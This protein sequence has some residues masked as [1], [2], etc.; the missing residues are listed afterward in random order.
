MRPFR[1]SALPLVLLALFAVV[2]P[3]PPAALAEEASAPAAEAAAPAATFLADYLSEVD[4]VREQIL[5]LAAA[6]P[7]E[8]Y[9]WRPAEGVR[10]VS[11]VYLHIA[12]A[13]YML[14]AV[15]GHAPPADLAD[16]LGVAKIQAWDTSTTDKAAVADKLSRSFDHLRSTVAGLAEADLEAKVDFFGQQ[17]T[18]RQLLLLALGHMHEHLG[19]SIAYAR[20]N[21]VAP[22]W[23]AAQQEALREAQKAG[24]GGE[25]E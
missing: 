15:A 11:E 8:T 22:P 18:K 3:C 9:A 17:P 5:A 7:Q 13:N 25:G 12:F 1:P 20:M 6:I 24:G 10:S 16:Q 2:A 4:R 14:P 21:G 23:T 19:Q